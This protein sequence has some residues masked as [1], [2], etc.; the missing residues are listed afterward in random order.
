MDASTQRTV[1][2]LISYLP[3]FKTEPYWGKA[4]DIYQI[5][6]D[7][8]NEF[9][10]L[11][12]REFSSREYAKQGLSEL[13]KLLKNDRY[14]SSASLE[15][16]KDLLTLCGRGERFSTGYRGWCIEEKRIELILN[17]LNELCLEG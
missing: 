7:Y 8:V 15:Q 14:I 17:R 1:E 16:L 11:I 9:F 4:Y 5:Y 10:E 12:E 3:M 6:T 2:K 13:E